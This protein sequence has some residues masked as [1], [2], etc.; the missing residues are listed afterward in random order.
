MSKRAFL[1]GLLLMLL[2]LIPLVWGE[3]QLRRVSFRAG[4]GSEYERNQYR[5]TINELEDIHKLKRLSHL[6]LNVSFDQEQ[7][8]VQMH[9]NQLSANRWRFAFQL[10]LLTYLATGYVMWSRTL[11]QTSQT[12]E[13]A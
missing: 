1:V 10:M 4:Y 3:V 11:K 7:A 6:L 2:S 8:I 12:S 5:I 9:R 13:R